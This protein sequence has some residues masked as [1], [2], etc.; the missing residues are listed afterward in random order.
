MNFKVLQWQIFADPP[1]DGPGWIGWV[2]RR[3]AK[4]SIV[5]GQPFKRL[6]C[7]IKTLKIGIAALEL[8]HQADR[9]GVMVKPAERLHGRIEGFLASV[10]ERCMPKVVRQSQ[11][12][13]KIVID[14]EGPADAAGD[15][16]DL[17]RM[18]KTRP[19]IVPLMKYKNLG[20][21]FQAAKRGAMNDAVPVALEMTS[22]GILRLRMETAATGRALGRKWLQM[23]LVSGHCSISAHFCPATPGIKGIDFR[24]LFPTLSTLGARGNRWSIEIA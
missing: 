4:R 21:M 1:R 10:T 5:F 2:D 3:F 7:Q 13:S 11:G 16:G 15:L 8:G 6:P 24:F 14:A 9:L 12:F 18:G 19:V 23:P 20:L 17:Y 22:I